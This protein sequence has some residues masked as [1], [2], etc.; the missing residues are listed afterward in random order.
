MTRKRKHPINDILTSFVTNKTLS[1]VWN[2]KSKKERG[3]DSKEK[4]KRYLKLYFNWS[5]SEEENKN[6]Y[7]N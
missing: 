4:K 7:V 2:I 5:Y 1:Y 6:K 3:Y